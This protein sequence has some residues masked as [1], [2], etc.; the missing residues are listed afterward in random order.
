MEPLDLLGYVIMYLGIGLPLQL[1]VQG[2]IAEKQQR[3]RSANA[4]A[5]R[6]RI[7]RAVYREVMGFDCHLSDSDL[8]TWL[9]MNGHYDRYQKQWDAVKHRFPD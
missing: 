2:R 9:T 3:K 1:V 7:R 5:E 6:T 8:F 4:T